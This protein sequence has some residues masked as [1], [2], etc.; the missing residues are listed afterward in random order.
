MAKC[1][2]I[3]YPTKLRAVEAMRK[4]PARAGGTFPVRVYRCAKCRAWH[5]TSKQRC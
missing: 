4:I 3:C 1:G 2:K 5:Y